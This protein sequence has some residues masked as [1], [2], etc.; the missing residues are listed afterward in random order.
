MLKVWSV[1]SQLPQNHLTFVVHFITFSIFWFL[2]QTLGDLG[3][4]FGRSI[5]YFAQLK[6]GSLDGDPQD[7]A[8]NFS[9]RQFWITIRLDCVRVVMAWM[10]IACYHYPAPF[11]G[12]VVVLFVIFVVSCMVNANLK[13]K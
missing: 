5:H 10:A 9:A 2:L 12:Q 1:L 8:P 6:R 4:Y 7:A 11:Y 3:A 13:Q